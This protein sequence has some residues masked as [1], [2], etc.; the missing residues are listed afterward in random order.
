MML[1][2]YDVELL[3]LT[4]FYFY[5]LGYVGALSERDSVCLNILSLALM[6]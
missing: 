2:C 6:K 1:N 4:E 3:W 5:F